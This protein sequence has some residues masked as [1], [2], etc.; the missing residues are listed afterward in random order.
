MAYMD[1]RA[2]GGPKMWEAFKD[3]LREGHLKAPARR[4]KNGGRFVTTQ[5]QAA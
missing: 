3:E 2:L 5:L 4:K 1:A